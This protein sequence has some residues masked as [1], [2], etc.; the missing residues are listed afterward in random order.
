M[1]DKQNKCKCQ[2]WYPNPIFN[3]LCSECY[4]V[5]N[6]EEY[7]KW[8]EL[9][10]N[11]YGIISETKLKKF[12]LD[13]TVKFPGCQ[14]SLLLN[15]VKDQ[16]NLNS[17]ITM[18]NYIKVQSKDF[19]GITADQASELYD[20]FKKYHGNKYE[21]NFGQN[22][23]WRWQHFFAGMIFD[24]WN[25]NK[26]KNGPV[27][28]CYYGNFGKKPQVEISKEKW[29]SPWMSLSEKN[30]ELWLRSLPV[31]FSNCLK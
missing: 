18:L 15:C 31:G 6:P 17:L 22:S 12:V 28:Y 19:L 20:V 4:S 5:S 9:Q 27:A 1:N 26:D 8:K 25:I 2:K 11:N 10:D 3:N 16:Q 13:N 21:G 23:D 14:W 24:K 29:I 30:K 7:K